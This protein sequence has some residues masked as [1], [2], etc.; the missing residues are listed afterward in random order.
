MGVALNHSEQ[1]WAEEAMIYSKA[2]PRLRLIAKLLS[3][4]RQRQLL[5]IGCSSATLKQLL[6]A[7]FDYYGCD[8]TRLAEA[9]LPPGHFLQADFNTG[10]DLSQFQQQ[11]I[12]CLHIGGVLE[13]LHRPKELLQAARQ[14]VPVHT[15][16]LITLINFEGNR[17]RSP[18]RHH[19]A[20]VYKPTTAA[21][22]SDLEQSGFRLRRIYPFTERQGWR[23]FG[24]YRIAN[25]LGPSHPWV[26]FQSR[27]FI[28][29]TVAI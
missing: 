13:Y 24:F 4:Q 10:V 26:K 17:F 3:R 27:Q 11:Q 1:Y 19:E 21:L 5:D 9:Q 12:D 2:H 16:L 25:M 28:Y 14:L 15:P 6:P 7:D 18:S 29:R 20:W 8:I 22:Q 23:G